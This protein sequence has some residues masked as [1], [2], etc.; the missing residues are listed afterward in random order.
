MINRPAIQRVSFQK[1]R[2]LARLEV[3]LAVFVLALA[4]FAYNLYQQAQEA[5][6]NQAN[7]D[8]RLSA[9]RDDLVL[10]ESNNDK[11]KLQEELR[12]LESTPAPPSLPSYTGAL[13]LGNTITEY[14]QSQKLPLTGFDRVDFVATL[15]E[16]EYPAVKFTVTAVGDEKRLTGMLELLNEFPTALVRTLEFIRP[17]PEGPEGE[18]ARAGAWEMKLNVDVFYR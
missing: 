7:Q 3:A 13:S 10:F 4:W 17:P 14:A 12:Q 2:P 6:E 8:R 9:L 5:E 15:D 16:A 1:L 18:D 11:E